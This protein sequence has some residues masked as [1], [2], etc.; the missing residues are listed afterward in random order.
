MEFD[1]KGY[2]LKVCISRSIASFEK[3]EYCLK[4][5]CRLLGFEFFSKMDEGVFE[6]LAKEFK[7]HVEYINLQFRRL[8]LALYAETKE[9][10]SLIPN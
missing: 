2:K 8:S 5:E 6:R 3:T 7:E 4:A 10:S 9:T 1:Y